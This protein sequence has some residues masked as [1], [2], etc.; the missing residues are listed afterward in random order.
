MAS[1]PMQYSVYILELSNNSYYVGHTNNL[2]RRLA[3]HKKGI[4]C[5]HTK[6]YPMK[7]L[8]WS[9]VHRDRDSAAAREKEIKGWSR[10]KK[11]ALWLKQ[12]EGS[13]LH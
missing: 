2:V 7:K 12:S 5:S 9:E 1:R 10:R 8:L 3:E 13:I 6:K 4:A 11:E